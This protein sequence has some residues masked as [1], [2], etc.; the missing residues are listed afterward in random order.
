[1]QDTDKVRNSLLYSMAYS[2]IE[3]LLKICKQDIS[4]DSNNSS[5]NNSN[6]AFYL[7]S[8]LVL[9]KSITV[10]ENRGITQDKTSAT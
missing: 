9:Y 2:N 1:M 3:V 4:E 7:L 6:N 8:H 5:N 10:G